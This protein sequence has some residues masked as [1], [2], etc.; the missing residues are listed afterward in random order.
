MHMR[1]K[2]S[3][4]RLYFVWKGGSAVL[5]LPVIFCLKPCSR[6]PHDH[7]N[8]RLMKP[9]DV[10]P[11]LPPPPP[12]FRECTTKNCPSRHPSRTRK[13]SSSTVSAPQIHA[14]GA[15][16]SNPF[17]LKRSTPSIYPAKISLVLCIACYPGTTSSTLFRMRLFTSELLSFVFSNAHLR[18]A[19][20][21]LPSISRLFVCGKNKGGFK[22]LV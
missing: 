8:H 11:I 14:E 4:F 3:W 7:V 16:F 19:L 10:L 5:L 22:R 15:W 21:C 9:R 20:V 1:V 17:P 18:R 12:V 13:T 6:S 2:T